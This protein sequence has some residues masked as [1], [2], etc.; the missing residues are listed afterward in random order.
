MPDLTAE[1]K[2]SYEVADASLKQVLAIPTAASTVYSGTAVIDLKALTVKGARLAPFEVRVSVPDLDEPKIGDT[3]TIKV[4][5][6]GDTVSPVDASS[7]A[8]ATDCLDFL[9][10]GGV[11]DKGKFYRYKV[12][13]DGYRILG[14]K[15]V[16]SANNVGALNATIELLF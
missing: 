7:V 1:R 6:V 13:T 9:G 11:G 10:A 16:A 2:T 5:L 14:L 8:L 12:S 3:E 4:S 15:I